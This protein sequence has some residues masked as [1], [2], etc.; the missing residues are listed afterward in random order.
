MYNDNFF[1]FQKN[2]IPNFYNYIQ[3]TN[4]LKEHFNFTMKKF[5]LKSNTLI[6]QNLYFNDSE[7][8]KSAKLVYYA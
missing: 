4:I 1:L 7:E 6:I 8:L 2:K 3:E 5:S